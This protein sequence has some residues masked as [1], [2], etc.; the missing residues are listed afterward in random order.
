MHPDFL[1]DFMDELSDEI[2]NKIYTAKQQISE[3]EEDEENDDEKILDDLKNQKPEKNLY[4]FNLDYVNDDEIMKGAIQSNIAV[5]LHGKPGDGKSARVK[6]LDPT[7]EVLYL[8]NI[9]VDALNGKDVYSTKDGKMISVK[10]VWL[11][12][13]EEKCLDEPDRIHLVFFDELTNA[14]PSIQG[15]AFN[16]VLDRV[17]NGMWRLPDNARIVAAGNEVEDSLAANEL[18]E[19][20]YNRFAHLYLETTPDE[21]V[22]WAKNK[23]KPLEPLIYEEVK[24]TRKIHPAIYNY[25]FINRESVFRTKYTG[26]SPNAD[27]RKWEMASKMLYQTNNPYMLKSLIGEEL[28]RDFIYFSCHDGVTIEEVVN[29]TYD[30]KLVSKM[31][32]SE[33]IT[34]AIRLSAVS[35]SDVEVVRDFVKNFGGEVT[36][37]FDKSWIMNDDE[38]LEKIYELSVNDKSKT[39]HK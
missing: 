21:W 36:A 32:L 34:T 4:N 29:D 6:R 3:L 10:P 22:N 16:I 1:D 5:F 8:R 19:P 37:L 33:K 35:I 26:E 7:C 38:R 14:T 30:R 28:T 23:N 39:Y 13:L 9:K 2:I 15:M 24:S 25:I 31:N 12:N 27:P 11:K 18:V 20:L 17:V